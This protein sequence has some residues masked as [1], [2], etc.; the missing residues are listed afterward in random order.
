MAYESNPGPAAGDSAEVKPAPEG[1]AGAVFHVQAD[2]FPPGMAETL[3][4]G[5]V[6]E[7]KILGKPDAE[8]DIPIQYNTGEPGEEG[9]EGG[10]EASEPTAEG[11]EGG[12]EG[13]EGGDWEG[14]ARKAL[15]PQTDESESGGY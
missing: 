1:K 13:A 8:G 3:K 12:M 5:E 11:T 6:I 10:A 15:S 9:A 7:F 2:M 14:E 4:P